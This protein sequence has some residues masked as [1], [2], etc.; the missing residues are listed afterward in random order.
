MQNNDILKVINY[1][2]TYSKNK[3]IYLNFFE[4]LEM[5]ENDFKHFF[6]DIIKV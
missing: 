6:A 4:A 2:I 1:I 3:C 5:D